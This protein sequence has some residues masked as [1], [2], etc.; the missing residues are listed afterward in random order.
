M[1]VFV[2]QSA[3]KL[4]AGSARG[5]R[6]MLNVVFVH[7]GKLCY[8]LLFVAYVVFLSLVRILP[9]SVR[10]GCKLMFL[11]FVFQKDVQGNRLSCFDYNI[12][13]RPS[14]PKGQCFE[15]F[16]FLPVVVDEG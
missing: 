4:S 11:L 9:R 2:T 3:Q 14:N 1:I 13:R 6:S 5:C 16:S 10:M 12:Q 8:F 7:P 15:F